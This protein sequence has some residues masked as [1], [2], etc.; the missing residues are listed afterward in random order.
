MTGNPDAVQSTQALRSASRGATATFM[1][2]YKQC[3]A[4]VQSNA[5]LVYIGVGSQHLPTFPA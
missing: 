2:L 5:Q 3:P 4:M 1:K